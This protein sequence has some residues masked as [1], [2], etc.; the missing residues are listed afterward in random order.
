[1]GTILGSAAAAPAPEQ[2]SA[3]QV[4]T[5]QAA[6][7]RHAGWIG[8]V[9]LLTVVNSV[10]MAAGLDWNFLVGLGV[11]TLIDIFARKG[12][13]TAG[14][15]MAVA[16]AVIAG[17]LF[18]LLWNFAR[19]GASWAFL[20]AGILYALD[21]LVYLLLALAAGALW[22]NVLLHGVALYYILKGVGA[23]GRLRALLAPQ[24]AAVPG[25]ISS[26]AHT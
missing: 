17:A 25:V 4:A 22:I 18:G 19:K 1:M 21:T 6:C 16:V 3:L 2:Q 23:A 10:G 7:R 14:S 20:V 15:V 11:T 26:S 12:A 8:I 9:A 13:G 24:A 5:A